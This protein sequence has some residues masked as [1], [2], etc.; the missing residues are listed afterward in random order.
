M[1][2]QAEVPVQDSPAKERPRC[3]DRS[4]VTEIERLSRRLQL[5]WME[6]GKP[7]TWER[8]TLKSPASPWEIHVTRPDGEWVVTLFHQRTKELVSV[9][10]RDF[11]RAVVSA[12]GLLSEEYPE[13]LS[14]EMLAR[15]TEPPE[16][17]ATPSFA[18]RAL[19][20]FKAMFPDGPSYIPAREFEHLGSRWRLEAEMLPRR[21]DSFTQPWRVKI[22]HPHTE[23][24]WYAGADDC[25]KAFNDALAEMPQSVPRFRGQPTPKASALATGLPGGPDYKDKPWF[26]DANGVNIHAELEE[27]LKKAGVD[28]R[29]ATSWL[30]TAVDLVHAPMGT[31][32]EVGRWELKRGTYKSSEWWFE[33]RRKRASDCYC[34]REGLTYW[35]AFWNTVEA[36]GKDSQSPPTEDPAPKFSDGDIAATIKRDCKRASGT[37]RLTPGAKHMLEEAGVNL[38]IAADWMQCA[39]EMYP[40]AVETRGKRSHARGWD[41]VAWRCDDDQWRFTIERGQG[42]FIVAKHRSYWAAFW[43]AAVKVGKASQPQVD[44]SPDSESERLP[45]DTRAKMEAAG[46]NVEVATKWRNCAREMGPGHRE[47]TAAGWKLRTWQQR[48]NYW[49]FEISREMGDG[50]RSCVERPSFWAAF[51]DC[52][53]DVGKA[54]QIVTGV[55]LATGPDRTVA[56]TMTVDKAAGDPVSVKD[57][58]EVPA[59]TRQTYTAGTHDT[60][61]LDPDRI[62]EAFKSPPQPLSPEQAMRLGQL[63]IAEFGKMLAA[64]D[65]QETSQTRNVGGTGYRVR[66]ALWSDGGVMAVVT[67]GGSELSR[68]NASAVKGTREGRVAFT[69]EAAVMKAVQKLSEGYEPPEL[70]YAEQHEP[71]LWNEVPKPYEPPKEEY[72]PASD[73]GGCKWL[74]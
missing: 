12:L 64:P 61:N 9:I 33:I 26:Q 20:E 4:L 24:Y 10:R 58:A 66:L 14:P 57:I 59:A 67:R 73:H 1:T 6:D 8:H 55:D 63:F 51:W 32:K 54:S 15:S 21:Q 40:V 36:V 23:R 34:R 52:V 29:M 13:Y 37:N 38:D 65:D 49:T 69:K 42:P 48:P 39:S 11:Q 45:P 31:S 16:L 43:G 46:V 50:W 25:L 27:R 44:P 2:A 17:P 18:E 35:E 60:R 28:V 62:M 41:L 3:R 22:M 74:G 47:G 5:H 56:V 19:R 70:S 68:V 30:A 71:D 72:W 7:D 53:K